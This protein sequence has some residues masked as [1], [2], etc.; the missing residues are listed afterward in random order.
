[1]PLTVC[2]RRR[3]AP[4]L[5]QLGLSLL[6]TLVLGSVASSCGARSSLPI[7]LPDPPPPDCETFEDCAGAEDLCLP[8]GCVVEEKV[9]EE[10][11]RRYLVGTCVDLEPVDCDDG[12]ECTDDACRSRDGT[13]SSKPATL[14]ADGDGFNGPRS[15]FTAGSEGSCGDDC[16]DTSALAYPGALEVCD[17]VDNDCNGI[18]DDGATW[19]PLDLEPIRLSND[20]LAPAAPGGVAWSGESWLAMFDTKSAQ[21]QQVVRS[22]LSPDGQE[23]DPADTNVSE[24]NSDSF[25][26]PILWVGDRYGAAWNDRRNADYE[27]Y[28]ALFAP[29]G[30]KITPDTRLSN[31]SGFSLY[32]DLAWTGQEFVVLWQD[33]R[34]GIFELYAQRL[35]IEGQLVGGETL[36]ATADFNQAEAPV[37]AATSLGIGVAYGL[38]TAED[39][40][41]AF[42]VLER[43]LTPRFEPVLLTDGTTQARYQAIA[44]NGSEYV[45]VWSDSSEGTQGIWGAIVDQDGAV[46]VA[47]RR[48]VDPGPGRHTRNPTV[49]ALGDRVLVVYADDR[50]ADAFE[51]WAKLLDADLEPLEEERRITDAPADTVVPRTAFGPDGNLGVLFRDDRIGEQHVW[52]TR[53]GCAVAQP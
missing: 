8:V 48:M 26:G 24:A 25:S 19:L 45:I 15:G 28:F 41:I 36:V 1:M 49:R 4:G 18:I 34:S 21:G 10:D 30:D 9:R 5:M 29:N 14:D 20:G 12:D 31:A 42:K 38:G 50:D 43:D 3:R 32:P 37:L 51:L 35:D 53:L 2:A 17:G 33:E 44:A 11:G 13:C 16:D 6:A 23:L 7:P 40:R 46:R 47:P 52:F 39:R 22:R 27:V